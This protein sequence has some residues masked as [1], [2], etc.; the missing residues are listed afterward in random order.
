MKKAIFISFLLSFQLLINTITQ[1]H[2]LVKLGHHP[3]RRPVTCVPPPPPAP[4]AHRHHRVWIPAHFEMTP[5]G[6]RHIRGHWA[7][8]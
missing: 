5:Y 8:G 6:R 1:A 2:V 4:R 7:R 3:H